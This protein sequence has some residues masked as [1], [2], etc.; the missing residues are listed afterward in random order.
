MSNTLTALASAL[1]TAA[2]KVEQEPIGYINGVQTSFDDKG[3][4][5]NE[6][7]K[8]PY[9]AAASTSTYTPAM[10]VT[11]GTD[12]TPSTVSIAI[13]NTEMSTWNST[14]EEMR[15][16]QNAGT[17]KAFWEDT[18]AQ[19]MRALRNSHEASL[20]AVAYKGG[21][22]ATGTAGTN[23][24]ASSIDPLAD[25][26][27]LLRDAG[28]AFEDPQCVISSTSEANLLKL[29]LIQQAQ[30]YG[31]KSARERGEV[32]KF[33]GFKLR[34][35]GQASA[36]TIGNS[37]NTYDIADAGEAAGQTTLSI[38][39]GSGTILEGDVIKIGSA[40]HQYIVTTGCT[41]AGDIVIGAG[42]GRGLLTAASGDD[43]V[44]VQASFT[45]NV[46]FDRNAIVTVQRPPII[47]ENPTIKQM[48][49][50][51]SLGYSYLMCECAGD[52]MITWRL[53]SCWG[54][55]VINPQYVI[56]LLG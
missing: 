38:D 1:Y 51:D 45:P 41:T 42:R 37:T 48:I 19:K 26:K 6:T 5:L 16:L 2:N 35:S 29:A 55:K 27:K 33:F 53:H 28:C 56:N 52:G 9:A 4:A 12:S 14:G 11:A 18:I 24:F 15:G 50:S 20:F 36:H 43:T 30:Q 31:D 34:V 3:A 46:C 25:V 44:A 54:S 13:D 22:Y 8:V 21:T 23:P 32:G 40:T 7:I 17:D 10:T 47:P 49:I 39:T